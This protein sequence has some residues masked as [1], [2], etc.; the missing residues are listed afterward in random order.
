MIALAVFLFTL[1]VVAQTVESVQIPLA[2]VL[3][4]VGSLA[5]VVTVLAKIIYTSLTNTVSELRKMVERLQKRVDTL[6]RGCGLNGCHWRG[7]EK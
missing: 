2:W 1:A 3:G 4:M 5:T 7:P 6:Q